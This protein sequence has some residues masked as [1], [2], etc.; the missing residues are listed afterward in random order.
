[1]QYDGDE[2]H[3]P[4]KVLDLARELM[5]EIDLDPASSATAQQVIRAYNYYDK[6][7]DGLQRIWLGRVWLNPP[8]S[9]PAPF[10]DRAIDMYQ[11]H[12]IDEC[13]ILVNNATETRWFQDL[14]C[15]YPACVLNRRISFWHPGRQGKSPRQGQVIFYLGPNV[16]RFCTV[17][18]DKGVIVK[19]ITELAN[20]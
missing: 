9:N 7:H 16:K 11:R 4:P 15:R 13:L 1:V 3:T 2:W 6:E 10:T 8:Y 18:Q 17:F 14:L 5:G 19:P 20:D 12:K